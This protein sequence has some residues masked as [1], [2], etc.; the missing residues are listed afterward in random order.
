MLKQIGESIGKVLRIDTQT[1]MEAR[2]R[3]ER[4]CIQV[5]INKPLINIVLIGRFEQPVSYEAIHKLCFSYGRV[6]HMK[7]ACQYTIKR[8]EMPAEGSPVDVGVDN[9]SAQPTNSRGVHDSA[10]TVPGS[11]I[12][13]GSEVGMNDIR[14]GP[15]T[16]V[17]RRKPGQNR[18]K[19]A[20]NPG[21]VTKSGVRQTPFTFKQG[22]D[23]APMGWAESKRNFKTNGPLN[24]P[25]NKFC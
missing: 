14:Y 4:L 3:Y 21:D 18:T 24:G 12:T 8:P 16:L 25:R 20:V 23:M 6:G 22:S 5:D 17:S 9:G 10:S 19:Y 15:W 2:G 11:G 1:A 13:N 7:E